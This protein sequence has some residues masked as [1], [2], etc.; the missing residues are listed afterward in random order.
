MP[1][2][3]I[4]VGAQRNPFNKR[5]KRS[6]D[7]LLSF[8]LHGFSF[9]IYHIAHI[10]SPIA[11]ASC[12]RLVLK[13]AAPAAGTDGNW[14]LATGE[15]RM[16]TRYHLRHLSRLQRFMANRCWKSRRGCSTSKSDMSAL[17][18]SKHAA[19]P[20][21][22]PDEGRGRQRDE[23]DGGPRKKQKSNDSLILLKLRAHKS[24]GKGRQAHGA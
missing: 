20:A 24:S 6:L 23:A 18:H 1:H 12:H 11:V 4:Q 17:R 15:W 9:A 13:I 21:K 19:W 3:H 16:A 2:T 5:E 10:Y 7:W 8:W 14:W 22:E